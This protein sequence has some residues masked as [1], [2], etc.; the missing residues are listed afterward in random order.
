M[1]YMDSMG[2]NDHCFLRWFQWF[3]PQLT[4]WEKKRCLICTEISFSG[5]HVSKICLMNL[6]PYLGK[7][8][9]IWLIYVS[10]GLLQ[11]PTKSFV[12]RF[13][14]VLPRQVCAFL[15]FG[16]FFMIFLWINSSLF[17]V[18]TQM[19]NICMEYLPQTLGKQKRHMNTGKFILIGFITRRNYPVTEVVSNIFSPYLEKSSSLANIFQMGWNHQPD[20]GGWWFP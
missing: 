6:Y 2:N 12:A 17:K 11:P 15:L 10:D 19:R 9:P 18:N 5:P 3:C 14:H 7:I 16:F 4:Q 13:A 1:P 8:N 20:K